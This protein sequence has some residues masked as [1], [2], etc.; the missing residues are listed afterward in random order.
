MIKLKEAVIVEGKYDKITLENIIDA[1]I[2][3]TNGFGIFKD[4][5]KR[6]L[7]R[8]LSLKDGIIVL[9][10]SDSAGRMIRSHL[11]QIC[12]DGKITN[13]YIPKLYG[14][15]KRKEKPS[16]EALLG[17]EGMTAEIILEALKKS[18][19]TATKGEKKE[20]ITKTDLF[21]LGLSGGDNSSKKRE[22]LSDFLEIPTGFTPNAFLD[23]INTLYEK[24]EFL[25]TV[26]LWQ[27]GKDKS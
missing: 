5:E 26:E 11:K 1:L 25:R 14:K 22:E 6:Q 24:E 12:P 27:Q 23:I 15:E 2:I 13:V 21:V 19:I 17:V 10:D 18:G 16:K 4:K 20:K 3:P 8:T 7:I 9:T